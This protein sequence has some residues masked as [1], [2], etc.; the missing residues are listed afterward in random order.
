MKPVMRKKSPL[1]LSKAL[2]TSC[3]IQQLWYFEF[4]VFPL[5]H[6]PEVEV[7]CE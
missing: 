3:D 4:H 7:F 5:V 2:V 1:W 6:E